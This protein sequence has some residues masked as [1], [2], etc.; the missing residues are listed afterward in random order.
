M[1]TSFFPKLQKL[2]PLW[3]SLSE[4]R[5]KQIL[6][7]QILSLVAAAGEV[8]NLGAL[9][10]VL[11][12]LANPSEGLKALGVFAQPLRALPEQ[13]LL[14]T[15]GL[16]FVLVVTISTLLRVFTIH[17]QLR[18]GAMIASDL[19]EQVFSEVLHKPFSWHLEHNTSQVLGHLTK[20]VDQVN[21][22]IKA[23]LV[24]V[25]NL[26]VVLLLGSSLIA[27]APVVMVVV[28]ALLA[29]FYIL[30]FRF[31]R[32]ALKSDGQRLTTNY[33]SS[34]QVVQEGLGGI[35]DV[36]IDRSQ[37]FFL[38][39]YQSR[40]RGYRLAVAAINTKAQVPRY[41]IE[42]MAVVQIAAAIGFEGTIEWDTTMPDDTLKKQLDVDCLS[43]FGWRASVT[44][45]EGLKSTVQLY[46]DYLES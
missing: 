44:L 18:L 2:K 20:D 46:S 1:I 42:G 33:Q 26:A 8:A 45:N 17:R 12:L 29:V 4:R 39:A 10:P 15:L 13:H 36:L 30:V 40:N 28:G 31:T 35:R 37:P 14:I 19:G 22:S 24:V 7:L 6:F 32:G 34:L 25:V 3:V 41:L 5:R 38:S 16:G 43:S 23:L 21:A 9:L 11:R 27:L